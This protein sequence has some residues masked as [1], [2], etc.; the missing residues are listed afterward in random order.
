MVGFD[1]VVTDTATFKC[2]YGRYNVLPAP[3]SSKCI[4]LQ[5]DIIRLKRDAN[6]RA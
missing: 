6:A 1:I 3:Y 4:A 5:G 2:C